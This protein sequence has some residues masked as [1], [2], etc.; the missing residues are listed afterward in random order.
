M[1]HTTQM[2]TSSLLKDRMEEQR[3]V[4]ED[5]MRKYSADANRRMAVLQQR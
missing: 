5:A 1:Q 4:Y 2:H 3:R